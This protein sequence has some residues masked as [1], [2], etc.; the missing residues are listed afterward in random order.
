[1]SDD[2]DEI[3]GGYETCRCCGK[4]YAW[5]EEVDVDDYEPI[6]TVCIRCYDDCCSDCVDVH[7]RCP[8]CV[9]DYKRDLET[10][11]VKVPGRRAT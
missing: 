6:Q 4:L 9:T 2:A 1:M 5:G 11:K 7:H 3:R 10:R 8:S